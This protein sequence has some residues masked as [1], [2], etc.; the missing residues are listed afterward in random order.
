MGRSRAAA[1]DG[2][3]RV[4]AENGIRKAS[5]A[6]VAVR[7]GL[8]KATLYNHFRTKS[9]L[10][11]GLVLDDVA[12][13]AQDCVDLAKD[14]LTVAL[15]RAADAVASHPVFVGLRIVEPTVLLTAVAP[16]DGAVWTVIRSQ[17]ER[18]LDSADV[19]SRHDCV[20]LVCR[21]LASFVVAPGSSAMRAQ[22]AGLLASSLPAAI[23]TTVFATPA[24]S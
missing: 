16:D 3:R 23:R 2:A 14:D 19:S 6:D 1:L 21:W 5:M 20:D 8:A 22:Q 13:V 11:A 17:V 7:G 18:I 10:V 24:T 4:F 9:E 15:T 12:D